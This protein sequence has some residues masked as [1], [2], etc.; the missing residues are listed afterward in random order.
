MTLNDSQNMTLN[1]VDHSVVYDEEE[2]S[3]KVQ[4]D[5]DIVVIIND[6]YSNRAR[7]IAVEIM[8]CVENFMKGKEI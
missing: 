3:Y 5:Q 6:D 7:D 8:K 2:R 4:V 1:K